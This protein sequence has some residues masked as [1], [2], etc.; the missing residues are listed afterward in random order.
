MDELTRRRLQSDLVVV[1]GFPRRNAEVAI[2]RFK[3]KTLTDKE[4]SSIQY[5]IDKDPFQ[6]GKAILQ[7]RSYA[8]PVLNKLNFKLYEEVN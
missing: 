8:I 7:M 3:E 5:L 2:K 6:L 1:F 4:M